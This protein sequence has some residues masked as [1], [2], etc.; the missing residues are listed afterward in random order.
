MKM[1]E[2]VGDFRKKCK[3]LQDFEV[4]LDFSGNASETESRIFTR[5]S[6]ASSYLFTVLLGFTRF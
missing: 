1:L 3:I 5:D 2:N 4:S 6:V